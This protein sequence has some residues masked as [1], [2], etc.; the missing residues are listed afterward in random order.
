MSVLLLCAALVA[1]PIQDTAQDSGAEAPLEE[2]VLSVDPRTAAL[3]EVQSY[4]RETRSL[5]A[6]F[7]QRSPTGAEVAGDLYLA[8]PGRI[9]FD[10]GDAA[11]LLIVANGEVLSMVDT[12]IGQVTRWPVS[13]TPLRVLIGDSVDLAAYGASVE[14]APGGIDDL[15]A[16]NASDPNRPE[17]GEISL[18]FLRDLEDGGLD[19]VSWSVIDA[20][21]RLTSVQLH[22]VEKNVALDA[23]LWTFEDPRGL[24]RR[25]RTR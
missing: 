15:V 24:A 6:R 12:E 7:V 21:G 16:L 4:L 2:H 18:Y 14:V 22:D 23:D 17:L 1:T 19:L 8:K 10:Y 11:P 13:D 20:Q 3:G 25:R 9:R 5:K